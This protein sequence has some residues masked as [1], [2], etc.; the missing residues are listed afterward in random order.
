MGVADDL[1]AGVAGV[2]AP[3]WNSRDGAV[4]P[5]TADI[6]L[7]NGAVNLTATYLYA[8]M[9]NSTALAQKYD[10][11][12]TAKV[13][14]CYLNAASRLIRHYGG[15]IRSYDGDR[16]MGIFIGDAKNTQ[17]VR[18]GLALSWAVRKVIQPK[19]AA[20]WTDLDWTMDHGV[21]VDTGEAMLVRA[22]VRGHNDL[23][24]VG[25]APNIAA[26]LSE[27]RSRSITI[28]KAVYDSM[29]KRVKIS[30][31]GTKNMWTALGDATLGGK[32][33]ARYGSNWHWKP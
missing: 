18:C 3:V 28:S 25:S 20:K 2:L 24:S 30:T 13:I 21:G 4:I 31:D 22:G 14:R 26:K 1:E 10:R 11:P 5:E 23:I 27:N 16:V 7:N 19:L 33:I 12:V 29:A 6:T 8:D 15:E 9:A 17:S 32:V